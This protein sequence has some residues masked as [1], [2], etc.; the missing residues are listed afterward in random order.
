MGLIMQEYVSGSIWLCNYGVRYFGCNIEARMTV[1][2]M[3]DGR[4]M[5]HSPCEIKPVLKQE[6]Q[7]LGK[8]AYIVAPSNFHYLHVPSAQKAFPDAKT[9][10]CPGV[11]KKK[12]DMLFDGVLGDSTRAEWKDDLDQVLIQGSRWMREA[13]FFHRSSKT[14]ILVDLVENITDTTPRVNW[15]LKFWWKM[16]FRMWNRPLPAPEYRMGWRDRAAARVSLKRIMEWDFQ[17]VVL[18]HGDLIETEAK[19]TV[20]K[21]WAAVL[22]M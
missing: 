7:A 3:A 15:V 19:Q 6:I 12:P 8:V 1:I 5:L 13:V 18:A 14:L 17:R 9:F 2:R 16:V 20:Q 10:I 22:G 21:A 4:L 11:E